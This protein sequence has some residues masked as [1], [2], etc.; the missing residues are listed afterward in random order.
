M[1]VRKSSLRSLKS[2]QMKLSLA[3]GYDQLCS[4]AQLAPRH[5]SS[6]R[7][8]WKPLAMLKGLS[9]WIPSLEKLI[10]VE[11]KRCD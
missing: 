1:Q 9:T 7:T 5:I 10:C 3:K 11:G 4:E 8:F 6:S 2:D